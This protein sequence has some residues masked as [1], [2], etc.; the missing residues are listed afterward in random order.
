MK[1]KPVFVLNCT[2]C[3]KHYEGQ[4]EKLLALTSIQELVGTYAS[5][6]E[7][8]NYSFIFVTAFHCILR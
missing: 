5:K 4:E 8:A 2:P 6:Y 7:Y 1:V 3:H